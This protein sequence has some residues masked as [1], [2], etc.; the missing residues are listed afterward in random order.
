[1]TSVLSYLQHTIQQRKT[2]GYEGIYYETRLI[3]QY[4]QQ[5]NYLRHAQRE[6]FETYIYLKEIAKNKPLW[7]VMKEQISEDDILD[8][9]EL[10]SKELRE[11]LSN[12]DNKNTK[13][14]SFLKEQYG[15]SDYSDGVYALTMG[16]GK[17]V[18]MTMFILYDIVL[19]HYHPDDT[20]FAKNFLVFAPDTTIIQS[21][22]EIKSFDYS[23]VI[24]PEYQAILVHIKYHYLED[25][26][27]KL[28]IPDGSVYN[29]VVSNSQ[30]IIIKNRKASID[31]K[32]HLIDPRLMNDHEA[33]NARLVS[34]KSLSQL[35]IFVD[36]AHHSF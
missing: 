8:S 31:I 9:L 1:M 15:S 28:S 34:I 3:L 7:E 21:L 11:I 19:S 2:N 35:A 16:T 30:K 20:K 36:E 33:E 22:K 26:K 32:N 17:T 23:L 6:A 12:E 10:S 4:I 25:T 24:P 18:L 13:I 29:I 5:T 27:Q 14:L